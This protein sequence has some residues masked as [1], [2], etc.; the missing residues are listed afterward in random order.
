MINMRQFSIILLMAMFL[1]NTFIV[2]AWAMPCD[3]DSMEM[4]EMA[5]KVTKVAEPCDMNQK[6]D[7]Q[8]P[9]ECCEGLCLCLHTSISQTVLPLGSAAFADFASLADSYNLSN[10]R[11]HSLNHSP[12]SPPPKFNS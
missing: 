12:D 10:E 9:I 4:S 2:S 11:M 8:D 6:S 7:S 1:A 5:S 3:M